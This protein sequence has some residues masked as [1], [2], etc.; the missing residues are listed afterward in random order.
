MAPA[1]K[2]VFQKLWEDKYGWVQEDSTSKNH[3]W[4]KVC[5]KQFSLSNMGIQAIISHAASKKHVDLISS[6]KNH[7]LVHFLHKTLP[8]V[9]KGTTLKKK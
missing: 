1:K 5:K 7:G 9:S 6:K 4:C 8:S 2:S 3:A